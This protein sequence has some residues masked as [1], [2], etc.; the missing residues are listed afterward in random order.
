[1]AHMSYLQDVP[2]AGLTIGGQ[3]T[4]AG[5]PNFQIFVIV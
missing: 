1:M 3:D 5:T 2:F 4:V